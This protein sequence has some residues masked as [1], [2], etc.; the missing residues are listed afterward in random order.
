MPFHST[1]STPQP[2]CYVAAPPLQTKRLE[3]W[4]TLAV[5]QLGKRVSSIS[6]RK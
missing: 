5:W 2:A 1:L 3:G 4:S 6:T